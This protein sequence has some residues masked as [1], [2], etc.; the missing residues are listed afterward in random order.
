[1]ATVETEFDLG[2]VGRAAVAAVDG[3][4]YGVNGKGRLSLRC[5][6]ASDSAATGSGGGGGRLG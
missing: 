3:S 4:E 5:G 6:V 1:M 2:T